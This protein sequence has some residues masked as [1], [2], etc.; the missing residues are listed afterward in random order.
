MNMGRGLIW[1]TRAWIQTLLGSKKTEI[2][3]WISTRNLNLYQAKARALCLTGT[4][5]AQIRDVHELGSL[6]PR[7]GPDR[8]S[9]ALDLNWVRLI[10]GLNLSYMVETSA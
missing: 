5:Y 3:T 9:Q 10:N 2:H 7:R 4:C 1:W 6:K 8:F